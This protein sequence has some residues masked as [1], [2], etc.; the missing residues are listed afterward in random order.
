MIRVEYLI[1]DKKNQES[2]KKGE[3]MTERNIKI[4]YKS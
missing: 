3:N 1:K 4:K 2:V